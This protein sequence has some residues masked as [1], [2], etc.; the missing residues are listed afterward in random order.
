[1]SC[2]HKAI[3]I[4]EE[5]VVYSKGNLIGEAGY[6]VD[7]NSYTF[8]RYSDSALCGKIIT[9]DAEIIKDSPIARRIAGYLEYKR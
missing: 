1:M 4:L 9:V 5:G 2:K 3:L 8:S 7:C 6:C